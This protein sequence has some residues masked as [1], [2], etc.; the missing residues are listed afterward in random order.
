VARWVPLRDGASGLFAAPYRRPGA[1]GLFHRGSRFRPIRP[2]CRQ[3]GLRL[4]TP[5]RAA[6]S[7]G[8]GKRRNGFSRGR[9]SGALAE[10]P[11]LVKAKSPGSEQHANR[12]QRKPSTLNHRSEFRCVE[13][14]GASFSELTRAALSVVRIGSIAKAVPEE[15]KG[16]DGYDDAGDR[17]HQPRIE[18][19]HTD[20]LSFIE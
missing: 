16:K 15:I 1:A 10:D 17:K 19:H 9:G 13:R 2:N 6:E 5:R 14:R 3:A 7:V 20:V 18:R 12:H 8:L 11:S 4:F